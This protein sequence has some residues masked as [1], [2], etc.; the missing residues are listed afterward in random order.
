MLALLLNQQIE[1]VQI[2]PIIQA[3]MTLNLA[4]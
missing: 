4:F 2:H 1:E 3:S